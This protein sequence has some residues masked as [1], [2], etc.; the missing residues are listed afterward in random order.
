MSS[1]GNSPP[2]RNVATYVPTSG[3]EMITP[4]RMRSPAPDSRSSGSE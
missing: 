4:C 1:P 3:T 2:N